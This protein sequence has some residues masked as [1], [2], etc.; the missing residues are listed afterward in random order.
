M[1][2]AN[3]FFNVNVEDVK[4]DVYQAAA[5]SFDHNSIGAMDFTMEVQ[6]LEVAGCL[7][8][9]GC[10]GSLGTATGCA[11]TFGS[12]GSYGCLTSA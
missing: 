3:D 7:G 2:T 8:T 9:A 12:L 11:G 1:L 10:Y 4:S 6:E 5:Q